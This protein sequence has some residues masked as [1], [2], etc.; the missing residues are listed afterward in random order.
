MPKDT[1]ND[2]KKRLQ[3][4]LDQLDLAQPVTVSDIEDIIWNEHDASDFNRLVMMLLEGSDAKYMN[5]TMQV[6]QEAWNTFPHQSLGGKAPNQMY[7]NSAGEPATPV[8]GGGSRK[9]KTLSDV[10]ADT[11]PEQT[12]LVPIGEM[13]WGFEYPKQW[14]AMTEQFLDLEQS[15]KTGKAY[16][17]ALKEMLVLCP[18]LF[19]AADS[20]AQ[21]YGSQQKFREIKRLYENEIAL[22]RKY[23][24]EEFIPGKHRIIWAYM[25]NRPFLRMLDNY[26]QFIEQ[27]EKVSRAIPLYEELLS[28]NPND[29][30]GVRYVLATA[31][32]KTGQLEQLI[33]L[34]SGYPEEIGPD[35]VMG[36]VLALLKL[37]M[38]D[39]ARKYL[40][41]NKKYQKHTI[42][43]LL[44]S[45]H[46]QPEGLTEDRMTVGGED[47]AWYYWRNQGS[48]WEATK[49]A[50][51]FLKEFA[52]TKR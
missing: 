40:K 47:E 32:L 27:T 26:A 8:P 22:A 18:E 49:G 24:P 42:H 37:G 38:V 21:H 12:Q 7:D 23:I 20:L 19:D 11:Y 34:A 14:H 2:F 28:F 6:V 35:L 16:E 9:R 50:K 4:V 39:E 33:A 17:Q 51:D 31:Y 10:F 3:A 29:N 1:N 52:G 44:K 30:Q 36:K 41:K 25:D 46:P 45:T 48:F 13:E 43:E 5:D 15:G